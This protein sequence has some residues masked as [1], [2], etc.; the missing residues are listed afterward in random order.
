MLNNLEVTL[1]IES[2]QINVNSLSFLLYYETFQRW[3]KPLEQK[4][5]L[6]IWFLNTLIKR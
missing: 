6:K 1:T 2:L 3:T 4:V 5:K